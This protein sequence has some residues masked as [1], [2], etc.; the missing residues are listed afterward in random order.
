[1]SL[2]G[3]FVVVSA[4]ND[5]TVTFDRPLSVQNKKICLKNVIYPSFTL[6]NTSPLIF[7]FHDV[8]IGGYSLPLQIE[9][10]NY[11][12]S[13]MLLSAVGQAMLDYQATQGHSHFQN[14][15]KIRNSVRN[16]NG[17]SAYELYYNNSG[18]RI[19]YDNISDNTPDNIFTILG[20]EN[21][22]LTDKK[23]TVAVIPLDIDVRS[24][25]ATA[26]A[27]VLC[28]AVLPSYVNNKLRQSVSV[29]YLTQPVEGDSLNVVSLV[30]P[31]YHKFIFNEIMSI[32]FLIRDFDRNVIEF[33]DDEYVVLTFDIK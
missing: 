16:L 8:N 22:M 19:V 12:S 10:K 14:S 15:P 23:M 17:K 29:V 11:G 27:E 24:E 33:N 31:V 30:K 18:L 1:M 26:P 3:Q 5:F 6:V 28:N 21:Y 2:E 20:V 13:L 4:G 32:S 9:R 7:T 25:Q